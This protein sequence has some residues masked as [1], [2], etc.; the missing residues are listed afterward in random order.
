MEHGGHMSVGADMY[1]PSCPQLTV[2]SAVTRFSRCTIPCCLS[3]S[4]NSNCG[5][6]NN[7]KHGYTSAEA[8]DITCDSC[9]ISRSCQAAWSPGCDFGHCKGSGVMTRWQLRKA[10]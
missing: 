7:S 2:S 8:L 4:Y 6:P 1:F 10:P 3:L 5:N 9:N